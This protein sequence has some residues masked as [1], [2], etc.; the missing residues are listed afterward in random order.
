MLQI[1]FRQLKQPSPETL[2]THK[3][4]LEAGVANAKTTDKTMSL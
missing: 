1:S 2:K 4:D 3:A